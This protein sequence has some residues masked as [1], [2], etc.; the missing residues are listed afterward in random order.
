MSCL[1][2][3]LLSLLGAGPGV[4]PPQSG[5]VAVM[6]F[7]EKVKAVLPTMAMHCV[8]NRIVLGPDELCYYEGCRDFENFHR[9]LPAALR[10]DDSNTMK[11]ALGYLVGYAAMLRGSA[12]ELDRDEGNDALRRALG[13]H[14]RA[15]RLSLERV[16]KKAKGDEALGAAVVLLALSPDDRKATDALLLEMKSADPARRKKACELVGSVRLSQPRVITALGT[17][18]RAKDRTVRLAAAEA[19]WKIGPR[20]GKVVPD[21]ISL[22]ERGKEAWGNVDPFMVITFPQRVNLPLLALAEMGDDARPA[23]PIII[24]LLQGADAEMKLSLLGSLG[25]LGARAKDAAPAVRQCLG[26]GTPQVRLRA[27]VVLLCLNPGEGKAVEAVAA[28]LKGDNQF[29]RALALEELALLGQKEKAL[30]PLLAAILEK[31]GYDKDHKMAAYAVGRMGPIAGAAVPALARHLR[32]ESNDHTMPFQAAQALAA[33]GKPAL[34]ALMKAL[35]G[36]EHRPRVEA[37]KDDANR[38]D[39]ERGLAQPD[40]MGRLDATR[41][42]GEFRD[43]KAEV[44][45]AL[46]KA[47]DDEV[48][49]GNAA[50]ALGRLKSDD[51]RVKAA[52]IRARDRKDEVP[53]GAEHR[54]LLEEAVAE[55]RMMAAWALKQ[56]PQ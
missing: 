53:E 40:T 17:A 3:A 14:V 44:V 11:A 43:H 28:A 54:E 26:A 48:L 31:K 34:P 42:L 41:V 15:I 39:L 20:A 51:P 18:L 45:P 52:L 32:D 6:S 1:S 12:W 22:L 9:D 46:L 24:R 35:R 7:E 55:A 5:A 8:E 25:Q 2:L 50:Y 33:I 16:L 23:I 13:H 36:I 56:L 30:V 38:S 19:A 47:L 37:G 49:R 29:R 21:L 4:A 27:A 10:S